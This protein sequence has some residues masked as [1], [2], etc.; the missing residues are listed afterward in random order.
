MSIETDK[1]GRLFIP[2]EVREK[3]GEKFHIV[4][5]EDRVELM[6]VADDPLTAVHEAAGD[7]SNAS[8]EN[9]RKSISTAT[10]VKDT[11]R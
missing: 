9:I 8:I 11:N 1:Q 7:L 2:E 4:T 5:C 10:E 3:Y 6:P